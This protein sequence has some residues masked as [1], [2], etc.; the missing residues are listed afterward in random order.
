MIV[1]PPYK[2]LRPSGSQSSTI[3]SLPVLLLIA[4][5]LDN[6]SHSV[7]A[8]SVQPFPLSKSL[9]PIQLHTTTIAASKS[10]DADANADADSNLK[11]CSNISAPCGTPTRIPTDIPRKE[12]MLTTTSSSATSRKQFISNLNS[13]LSAA[14]VVAGT[15][16]MISPQAAIATYIDPKTKINLPLQNEIEE[17][18]PPDWKDID[19]PIVNNDSKSS[20]NTNFSRLDNSNDF[21]FYNQPRFVE[22]I[23]DNAVSIVRN[24]ISNDVFRQPNIN[25]NPNNNNDSGVHVL[26]LCSSWTSHF[27]P[28]TKDA[29]NIKRVA[30]LGMNEL[31]L[32]KNNVLTD[33]TVM[34]LN[35]KNSENKNSV[36]LPY[37]DSSFDVVLCQLSIDYLIYPIEVMN[38][39]GRVLKKGGRV[40]II[41]SNR[42]FLQKAVGL[43]TG[44]DDIDHAF[45]VASYL[46]F[47]NGGFD[48]KSIQAKDLSSRNRK[49]MIVGDPVY[50]VSARK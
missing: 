23:D 32:Q 2:C 9:R 47:S 36:R 13:I 43:W 30:G 17:S 39:I 37:D 50:V 28:Q 21:L 5:F 12:K 11:I 19:N 10:H 25:R 7:N 44:A 15:L 16:E 35:E 18:I 33:Y 42:L 41:F 40:D 3:K 1:L 24:Y 48:T 29:L 8:F 31:E 14:T 34:N 22:H 45:I 26:D 20:S 4:L 38:E 6:S 49:G 27:T 46:Y